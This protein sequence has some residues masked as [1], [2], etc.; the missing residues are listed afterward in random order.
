MRVSTQACRGSSQVGSYQRAGSRHSSTPNQKAICNSYLLTDREKSVFL[1]GY[2]WVHE[3]HLRAGQHKMNSV[4]FCRL[5]VSFCL[6]WAFSAL[7]VFCLYI[8][9]FIS[10]VVVAEV[11]V[12]SLF[13]GFFFFL[14]VCLFLKRE[15]RTKLPG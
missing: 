14:V 13:L 3:P 8:L 5:F 6:V 2:H 9:I 11:C 4:L 15:K 7:L 12:H 1:V 10:V